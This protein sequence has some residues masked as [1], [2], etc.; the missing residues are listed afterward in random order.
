MPTPLEI[1]LDPVSLTI[2]FIYSFLMLWEFLR[3]TRKLREVSNWRIEGIIS[4]LTFLYLG[5]YLPL[6]YSAWLPASATSQVRHS[7]FRSASFLSGSF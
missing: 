5:R 2:L 7:G 3:P 4:F 1:L 6:L